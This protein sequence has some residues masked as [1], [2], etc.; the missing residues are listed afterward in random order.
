MK[1]PIKLKDKL[2]IYPIKGPYCSKCMNK[3]YESG[4]CKFCN[5]IPENVS[6]W[7]F[8]KIISLGYYARIK[9]LKG[10]SI[11]FNNIARIVINLKNESGTSEENKQKLGS[12]VANGFCQIIDK[13]PFLM[14]GTKYLLI[15]PKNNAADQNQC[16]FFLGP[17]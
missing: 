7:Y 13:N 10:Q 2:L 6:E 1:S 8:N 9:D 4:Q 16:E 11:P 12:Y 15:P 3:I 5:D 17:L 14:E